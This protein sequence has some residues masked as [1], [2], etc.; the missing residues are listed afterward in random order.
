[1][2]LPE[3]DLYLIAPEILITVF[4]FLVLLIDVFSPKESGKKN[5]GISVSLE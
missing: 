3:I 4:G 1:M 5:L 2:K